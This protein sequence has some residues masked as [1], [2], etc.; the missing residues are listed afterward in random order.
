MFADGKVAF[1]ATY[2]Y[3]WAGSYIRENLGTGAAQQWA[4]IS[5]WANF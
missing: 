2:S 5:L 1:Q 4:Y 3:M